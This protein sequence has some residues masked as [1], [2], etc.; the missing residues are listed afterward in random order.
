[1]KETGFTA[2]FGGEIR[3]FTDVLGFIVLAR[4][5]FAYQMAGGMMMFQ[6]DDRVV[7]IMALLRFFSGSLELTGGLLMLYFG[8]VPRALQVNGALALVGPFVLVAVTAVGL[9]GLAGEANVRRIVVL[10]IGVAMIL[11]GSRS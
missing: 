10:V 7:S 9:A 8:T 6:M 3:F 11:Y 1:M 2:A 5:R 4:F